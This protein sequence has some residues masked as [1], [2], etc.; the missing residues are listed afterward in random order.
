MQRS[1]LR[2]RENTGEGEGSLGALCCS[3]S[4]TV[5]WRKKQPAEGLSCKQKG[6]RKPLREGMGV[7]ST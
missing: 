4:G 2:D 3:L 1:R 7:G 6:R 5:L